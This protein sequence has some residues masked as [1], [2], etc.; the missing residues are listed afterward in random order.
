MVPSIRPHDS[1]EV[2]VLCCLITVA[3]T[4]CV[5][6]TAEFGTAYSLA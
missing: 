1:A 6:T 3:D 5:I 4:E 2:V